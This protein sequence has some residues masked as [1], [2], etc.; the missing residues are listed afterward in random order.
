MNAIIETHVLSL[1]VCANT[2]SVTVRIVLIDSI[3]SSAILTTSL[4][5]RLR[6]RCVQKRRTGNALPFP[7]TGPVEICLPVTPSHE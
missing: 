4:S 7:L 3:P 5:L 1:L 2:G 6:P